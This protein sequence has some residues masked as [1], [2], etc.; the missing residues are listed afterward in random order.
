MHDIVERLRNASGT[1]DEYG[2]HSNL[3]LEAADLIESLRQKTQYWP[4]NAERDAVIRHQKGALIALRTEIGRLRAA[5]ERIVKLDDEWVPETQDDYSCTGYQVCGE[6]AR[7][8][9]SHKKD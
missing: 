6:I 5:L 7:A 1:F 3:E 4:D 2:I 8:A 9:L